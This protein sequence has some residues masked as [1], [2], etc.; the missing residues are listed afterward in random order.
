MIIVLFVCGS[1]KSFEDTKKN[2]TNIT[3]SPNTAK[4]RMCRHEY[5]SLSPFPESPDNTIRLHP[6]GKAR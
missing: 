3:S 5:R 4:I 6:A 1:L 2:L